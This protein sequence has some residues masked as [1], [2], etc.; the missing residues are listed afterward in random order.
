MP[1]AC[2]GRRRW[3]ALGWRHADLP[4]PPPADPRR[5]RREGRP[6]RHR[7]AAACSATRCA[8]TSPRASRWSPPRRC[9]P[10]RSSPSCC[11]SCAATP[12]S[13]GCRSAASPSGTSGP[14]TNGDLGPVYGNQWRSWP[15]P[16]GRHIDQIAQVVD[17]DPRATPTPAATSSRPGTSPTSPTWRCA[18]CHTLFQF[19]VAGRPA[20]LPALPA[21]GR[22][23]PR[24][25]VQH[26]LLRAADPHG[27][28][29]HRPRGRRLRA[30][31]GRR[32]PLPQPPRPGAAAADPRAAA[33]ADACG[34]TRVT[35]ARRLR[36][37]AHQRRRLRPAPGHQG[38]H[39]RMTATEP[40][41]ARRRASPT[42]A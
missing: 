33:A 8:S 10:A 19:Y 11:G 40:D 38:P 14:T 35:R 36:P 34:S 41:R 12:T 6:H 32:A 21:L 9:T 26:R 17:A 15:T 18:P 2:H 13:A 1:A 24:R 23:L 27:R 30:H 29:G 22:R 5:G 42:T 7:H 20:E 25:A 16:D 37:R 39:R 31:A 3:A 4:R 28:P